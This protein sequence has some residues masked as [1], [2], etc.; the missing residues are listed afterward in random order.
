MFEEGVQADDITFLCLLSACSCAGLVDEAICC[1]AS[2]IT[3]YMISALHCMVDLLGNAGHLLEAEN[4][5]KAT[6]CKPDVAVWKALISACRL[7]HNV[8]MG[9]RVAK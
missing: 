8:E 3:E 5:I 2:M 6:P 1:C 9:E 4:V 7:Y